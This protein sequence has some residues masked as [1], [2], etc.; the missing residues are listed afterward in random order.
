MRRDLRKCGLRAQLLVR[1]VE[2]E[3][4]VWLQ[5]GGTLFS[6][7][8]DNDLSFPGILVGEAECIRQVLRTPLK[9]VWAINDDA[10]ARYVVHCCARYH[11]IVSFSKYRDSFPVPWITKSILS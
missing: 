10:F 4:L 5:E 9:L 11:D 6:P 7:D 1:D 8:A 2:N 3:I